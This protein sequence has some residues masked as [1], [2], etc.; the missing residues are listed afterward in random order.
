MSDDVTGIFEFPGKY[1]EI[2]RQDFRSVERETAFLDSYLPPR[3][4]VLDV[5]CGTG[6]TLRA[7]SKLGHR[8]TGVDQSAHFIDYAK[9]AGG[10][11]D[12]VHA[13]AADCAVDGRSISSPACS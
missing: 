11:I 9:A 1:Y 7:L 6:T 3:G 13:T 4:A 2:I 10:E 5:G 8:C 12:F